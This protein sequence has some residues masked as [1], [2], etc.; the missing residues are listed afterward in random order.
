MSELKFVGRAC[1]ASA[2]YAGD[3]GPYSSRG[4]RGGCIDVET[5]LATA[6]I[7]VTVSLGSA[8]SR[9]APR[10][11]KMPLAKGECRVHEA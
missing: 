1:G 11:A 7:V 5:S 3:D 2:G 9:R 10:P 4:L 6:L 8:T